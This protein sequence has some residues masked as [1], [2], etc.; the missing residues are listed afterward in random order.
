MM[1]A[2]DVQ[3]LKMKNGRGDDATG[4]ASSSCG[5]FTLLLRPP[6]DKMKEPQPTF[7]YRKRNCTALL[8]IEIVSRQTI[9][10]S[11]KRLEDAARKHGFVSPP[12]DPESSSQVFE[13]CFSRV[14]NRSQG[15]GVK[16][17]MAFD[18]V[19]LRGHPARGHWTM[20]LQPDA[21]T[22]CTPLG[23]GVVAKLAIRHAP[24][25]RS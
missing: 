23:H 24:S 21:A 3:F 9:A 17:S 20:L 18:Q 10:I 12:V 7:T 25:F 16:N 5:R 11:Q 13:V 8:Q 1:V 22:L 14:V 4:L 2:V 15:P 6:W 19:L